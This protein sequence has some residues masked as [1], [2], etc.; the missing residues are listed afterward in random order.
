MRVLALAIAL[1]LSTTSF[2]GDS[3][4]EI[5]K[6]IQHLLGY[7]KHSACEFNRNGKW[8]STEKAVEH[9]ERKYQ[10]LM[11][12]GLINSAEQFIERAA[13]KSSMSGKPYLVKCGESEPMMSS[14]WL[15]AE[16][17]HHRK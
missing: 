6:E 14:V 2:A 17:A 3:K 13:S 7:L 4:D 16:L 11:K 15:K 8:Y 10:Y 9:I 5:D 1:L 12:R